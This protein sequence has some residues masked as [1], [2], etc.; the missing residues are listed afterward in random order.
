MGMLLLLVLSINA[1]LEDLQ[2][3]DEKMTAMWS[4]FVGE[5]CKF[6]CALRNWQHNSNSLD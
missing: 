1:A 2:R 6:Y 4:Y 5:S 3:V